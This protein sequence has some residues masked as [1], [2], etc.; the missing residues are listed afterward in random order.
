[1]LQLVQWQ[2]RQRGEPARPFVLKTPSHLGYLDTLLAEFPGA[3]LVHTHRDPL[4][5]IPSGASLNA[6]L[7]RTHSDQVDP[8]TVGRQ[9]LERMG[10]SNDRALAARDHIPASQITDIAFLD[11]VADPIATAGTILN[12]V[13]LDLDEPS[14]S[15]METWMAQDRKRETLPTH[16]YS[17]ADFGLTAEQI[18]DRFAVYSDR[19]L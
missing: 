16:R 2:K 8:H 15:A 11:A 10:W 12:A 13:G 17:A 1:M 5:V 6:T 4:E 18:L 3:H 9:W 7:W 19:F 14:V